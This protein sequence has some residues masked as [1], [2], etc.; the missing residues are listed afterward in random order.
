MQDALIGFVGGVG[1]A[2]IGAVIGAA[3]ERRVE[4]RKRIEA[5]RFQVYLKMMDVYN[6]Y[7]WVAS[8]EVTSGGDV[9]PD[10][11]RRIREETWR[12]ADL[13]RSEDK[14]P[15]VEDILRV[16]MSTDY[17]SAVARHDA[18]ISIVDKLGAAVNPRYQR[19]I[20]AISE[21]NLKRSVGDPSTGKSTT[22]GMMGPF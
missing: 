22:P 21:A 1:V 3:V 4:S 14:V 7:F 20:R 6:L 2:L 12:I 19:V 9:T 11:K 8:L 16:L 17:P 18:M 13:L 10:L 15:F 5:T